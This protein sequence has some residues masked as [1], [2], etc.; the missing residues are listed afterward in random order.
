MKRTL[1]TLALVLATFAIVK[2]DD[3][4]VT[5]NQLPQAAQT[6]INTNY[7]DEKV[8]FATVDDDFIRPDYHVALVS[9]VM[10][11]FE[12]S[13]SLEKI[14]TRNG[15]IP[16]GIIP[17]QIIDVVKQYY[18]EAQI[19]EYEIGKRSYEVKLSNRMEMKFNTKF[20]VIELDD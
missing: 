2:A 1:I 13:G 3:R 4:P 9:G 19:T 16:A 11:Q 20:Q 10:L 6:F 14:E 7:P 8:A 15:N 18:P 12:H 5:F 17:F